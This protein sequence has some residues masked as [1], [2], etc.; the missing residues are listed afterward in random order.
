MFSWLQLLG[1]MV[2]QMVKHL[3]VM[4]ETQV[5]SQGWEDPLERKWQPTPVLLP[6][7]SHGQR[8]LVGHSPRGGKEWGKTGQLHSLTKQA[9]LH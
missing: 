1:S 2:A 9:I 8:S 7:K 4:W 6:E 5:L 3:P